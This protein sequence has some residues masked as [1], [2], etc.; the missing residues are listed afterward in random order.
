M[1]ED[2]SD[3]IKILT[4]I[5]FRIN[6]KNI[7]ISGSAEEYGAW[8]KNDAVH[9]IEQ[10][11]QKLISKDYKIITGFGYGIGSYIINSAVQFID[12]AKFSHYDDYLRIR[13]FAFQ[14]T[15][16]EKKGF[17]TKYR[18]GIISECGISIFIFGNKKLETGD[19]VVADGVLEE[20]ELSK[21]NG[22]IIIPVGTT[23]YASKRIYDDLFSGQC[24]YDYLLPYKDIL[25][26]SKDIDKIVDSIIEII[27]LAK[28]N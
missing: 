4:A 10:L 16:I 26:T 23:G 2:Y 6:K 14:L 5:E 9:L 27:R 28:T 15:E 24:S 22:L 25:G 20:Y 7:F 19:I 18:T 17:N 21:K 12:T 8:S 11:T 3:V 13:P 1:M